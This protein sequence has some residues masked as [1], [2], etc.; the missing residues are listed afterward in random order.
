MSEAV[1][2]HPD[3]PDGDNPSGVSRRGFLG[4]VGVGA[5]GLGVL[6]F[7]GLRRSGDRRRNVARM[8]GVRED[9]LLMPRDEDIGRLLGDR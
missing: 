7:L 3:R 2:P 5:A 4:L 8:L 1:L 6:G 9:S